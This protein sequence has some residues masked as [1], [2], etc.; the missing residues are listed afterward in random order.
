[1]RDVKQ[2]HEEG[3]TRYLPISH[4]AACF[5]SRFPPPPPPPWIKALTIFRTTETINVHPSPSP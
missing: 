1:M 5:L 3:G 2:V 4:H